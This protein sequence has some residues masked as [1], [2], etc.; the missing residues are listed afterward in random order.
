VKFPWLEIAPGHAAPLLPVRFRRDGEVMPA[1]PILLVETGADTTLLNV[2]LAK[3]LGY[4]PADL[5]AETHKA[6]SGVM[7]VQRPKSFAGLEIEIG[8]KWY[9]LP[10]VT[11]AADV[12]IS[13]LGR[14]VIFTH[15]ELRMTATSFELRPKNKKI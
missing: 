12:P 4:A 15:F 5:V 14:D 2:A 10:S 8:R 3:R 11:F 6:A 7:T 13:L 1:A 9:P